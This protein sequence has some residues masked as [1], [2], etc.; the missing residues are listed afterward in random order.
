M[1]NSK[2]PTKPKTRTEKTPR[3]SLNS[4]PVL[5][6]CK[7]TETL[8]SETSFLSSW[9]KD[10]I[11]SVTTD[12]WMEDP[13]LEAQS[14]KVSNKEKTLEDKNLIKK[15]L[16]NH[17]LFTH[18]PD[19]NIDQIIEE[20]KF[21]ELESKKIIF[22][23]GDPGYN[24]FVLASGSVEV[25]INGSAKGTISSGK[26]F[27]ELALIHDSKR[28]AT[29]KT[30]EKVQMWGIGRKVFRDALKAL[31]SLNFE[32]NK[33][34]L[35]SVP[36]LKTL[37]ELQIESLVALSVSQTFLNG[38]KIV[39]E[40]DPGELF[41]II[42][43]GLVECSCAGKMVRVLSSGEYFGEQALLYNT[44][45]TATVTAVRK[46]KVLC[47]GREMLK[48][49]LGDVLLYSLYKNSLL[50]SIDKEKYLQ[51]LTKCQVESI[52]EKVE[53]FSYKNGEVVIPEGTVKNKYIWILLKGSLISN[54]KTFTVF[55]NIGA[56]WL[57]FNNSKHVKNNFLAIN[58][59]DVGVISRVKLEETIDGQL[60]EV[61]EHN[62]II[63]ILKKVS[64]FRTLP[65]SKL[66]LISKCV[67]HQEFP[68]NS[69]VF[70]QGEAGDQFFIV[71]EGEVSVIRDGIVI[72]KVTKGNFFG[73]RSMILNENRTA[74]VVCNKKCIFWVTNRS[75]FFDIIDEGIHELLVKRIKLQDDSIVLNDLAIVNMLGKG[76]FGNVYL[77]ANKKNRELYALKS[78]SRKKII[79]HRLHECLN[80][81]RKILLSIEHQ[82]IVK[83]V[84]TFKDD[85]RIYFLLE[86]V[87]GLCLHDVL[88]I[89]NLLNTSKC[90]FY[91]ACLVLILEH[92]HE[93]SIVYR[94]LKPEN[95][96]VDEYGYLKLLDFGTAKVIK[97][98]TFTVVGT[99]QYM[100]PEIIIGKGYS[101]ASDLWSLGVLIFEFICGSVPFGEHDKDPFLV[102]KKIISEDFEYPEFI[103]STRSE[104]PVIELLLKKNPSLR[105]NFK[106]LK[107]NKW[108]EGIDW[109]DMLSRKH[110]P[111]YLPTVDKIDKQV[112]FALTQNQ[113]LQ[114]YLDSQDGSEVVCG[115]ISTKPIPA[116]WDQDF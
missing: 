100:A 59:V 21:Y 32:E 103:K 92:L 11:K 64:I 27:G 40:G 7:S 109:E 84:K 47:L 49:V 41:Y 39:V 83:L 101:L 63:E 45:R 115:R 55:D 110:S 62:K 56:N 52:L 81:E 76:T 79:S 31:S 95:L 15:A 116:S 54:N 43:E 91:A 51:G 69:T 46:V 9:K 5:K 72:R 4:Q 78:V 58:D 107:A 82:F 114:N 35:Q 99:P 18:L 26:G 8:T 19:E 25:I 96:M 50:I 88:R 98:R 30:H 34:F 20:M 16:L 22:R 2:L 97:G 104:R 66:R 113:T 10:G 89:L 111:P 1:G 33:K 13:D 48:I 29:I 23:Q 93:N 44:L 80:L 57:F 102:Y 71:K 38:Q 14:A 108:F 65:E 17:F 6:S 60:G 105:G 77:C 94:D 74:S 61:I 86:Y 24:F 112:N 3:E 75:N 53:V 73:E 85:K 106:G 68:E 70:K 87:Q 28:T 67:S 37:S 36:F 42:K 12:Y 90:R